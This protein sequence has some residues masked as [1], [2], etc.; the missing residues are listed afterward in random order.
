VSG[1]GGLLDEK[2]SLLHIVGIA[3]IANQEVGQFVLTT[4][5]AQFHA[6]LKQGHADLQVVF[7]VGGQF[8]QEQECI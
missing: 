6:L 3:A 2:L 1:L 5:V 7:A 8:A 4:K